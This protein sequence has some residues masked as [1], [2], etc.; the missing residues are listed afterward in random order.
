[1]TKYPECWLIRGAH[2]VCL[3]SF[4]GRVA[5]RLLDSSRPQ[6]PPTRK[7]DT[8]FLSSAMAASIFMFFAMLPRKRSTW[9]WEFLTG[10]LQR[11]ILFIFSFFLS[12]FLF[13]PFQSE[14]NSRSQIRDFA[15][16]FVVHQRLHGE[17]LHW[18][19]APFEILP[20]FDDL[21]NLLFFPIFFY[22]FSY[23]SRLSFY[24]FLGYFWLRAS[25]RPR[26]RSMLERMRGDIR[27]LHILVQMDLLDWWFVCVF[28]NR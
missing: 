2:R 26:S 9:P 11:N 12:F 28:A 8:F 3:G 17:L 13:H 27:V 16:Q 21:S 19:V 14:P 6:A 15:G 10:P 25:E 24:C 1:M 5:L 23:F 18:V 22:L 7:D 20:R 4:L